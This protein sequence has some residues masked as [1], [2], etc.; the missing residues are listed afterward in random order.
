MFRR[1]ALLSVLALAG[2]SAYADEVAEEKEAEE[3]ETSSEEQGD[4]VNS[5]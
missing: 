4:G 2:G 3:P 1:I 5:P